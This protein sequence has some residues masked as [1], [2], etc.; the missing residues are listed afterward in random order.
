MKLT[1]FCLIVGLSFSLL[2][3]APGQPPSGLAT[4]P[5]SSPTPTPPAKREH[6]EARHP[7]H[8]HRLT[9]EERA[10][11]REQ[12]REKRQQEQQ[13]WEMKSKPKTE[14]TKVSPTPVPQQQ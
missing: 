8:R 4:S 3:E 1:A 12:R 9:R 11:R 10:A 7:R 13:Q 6:H 5:I 2:L 14:A